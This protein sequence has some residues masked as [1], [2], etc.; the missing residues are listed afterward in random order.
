MQ[1]A[2]FLLNPTSQELFLGG[3]QLEGFGNYDGRIVLFF[4]SHGA[5]EGLLNKISGWISMD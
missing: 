2:D 3:L 4:V 5:L 1:A